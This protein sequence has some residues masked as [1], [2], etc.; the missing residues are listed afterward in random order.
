MQY[1]FALLSIMIFG[2]TAYL[3]IRFSQRVCAKVEPFADGPAPGQ[4]PIMW[5]YATT[6]LIS[7]LSARHMLS[8]GDHPN[9]PLLVEPF[10]KTVALGLL[11][12]CLISAWYCDARCGIVPDW[13]T[14]PATLLLLLMSLLGREWFV[15]IGA[16]LLTAPFALQA[17][18]SKGLGMGWG[19]V[20]LVAL[21]GAF[22]GPLAFFT[23][24]L[25]CIA[26]IVYA[27]ITKRSHEPMAFAPYL[28]VGFEAGL[29]IMMT[30]NVLAPG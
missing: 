27:K 9:L 16:L 15:L 22:L 7:V 2:G 11:S 10:L 3:A 20:K 26:M 12:A 29:G 5:M 21:G 23:T 4:P 18:R 1:L 17:Y 28:V 8:I 19:D 25:S 30:Q 24:T 6:L 13:C 14:V